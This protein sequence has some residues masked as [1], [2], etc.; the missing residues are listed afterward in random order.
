[1]SLTAPVDWI[2]RNRAKGSGVKKGFAGLTRP[3]HPDDRTSL[4]RSGIRDTVS[5]FQEI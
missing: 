5:G 1:M 2:A 4:R 3:N